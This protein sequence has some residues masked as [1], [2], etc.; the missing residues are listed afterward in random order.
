[1]NTK[2]DWSSVPSEVKWISTDLSGLTVGFYNEPI[3]C[4]VMNIWRVTPIWDYIYIND[5]VFNGNWQDS[6]EE[7]P[8]DL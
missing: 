3:I 7:R 5:Q 2:Y 8:H 1:M 4:D 6:L